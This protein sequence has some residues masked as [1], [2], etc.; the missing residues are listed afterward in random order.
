M[1]KKKEYLEAKIFN[2]KPRVRSKISETC[3][4]VSLNLK[5]VSSLE[6]ILYR[7]RRVIWLQTAT[8]FG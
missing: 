6:L 8:V 7:M 3:I 4:R 2:L 1:N 5:I